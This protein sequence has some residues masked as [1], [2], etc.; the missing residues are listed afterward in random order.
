MA[1]SG[2]HARVFASIECR[3]GHAGQGYPA[4]SVTPGLSMLTLRVSMAPVPHHRG[5]EKWRRRIVS[6]TLLAPVEKRQNEANCSVNIRLT[7]GFK[8]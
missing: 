6:L 4:E 1:F 7:R 2:W 8:S 5:V 3:R